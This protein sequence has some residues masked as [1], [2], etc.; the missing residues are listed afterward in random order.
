MAAG[1]GNVFLQKYEGFRKPIIFQV[2]TQVICEAN[3]Y[4]HNG[5]DKPFFDWHYC[6]P[7]ILAEKYVIAQGRAD[8]GKSTRGYQ[9]GR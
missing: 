1:N 4:N 6:H 2:Y 7:D 3:F 9:S 8:F 5:P